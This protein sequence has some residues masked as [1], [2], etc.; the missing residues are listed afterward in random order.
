ME[1]TVGGLGYES[2]SGIG[3][4]TVF[5]QHEEDVPDGREV[6][7]PVVG[8]GDA[9]VS[10]KVRRANHHEAQPVLRCQLR[11]SGDAADI[12]PLQLHLH[13]QTAVHV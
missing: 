3:A 11:V 2:S 5:P 1:R 12:L 7:L 8:A 6:C 13:V 9:T 4:S 10:R